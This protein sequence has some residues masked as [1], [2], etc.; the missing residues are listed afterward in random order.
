MNGKLFVALILLALVIAL[1]VGG[2]A[3]Y[4]WLYQYNSGSLF[5]YVHSVNDQFAPLNDSIVCI[6]NVSGNSTTIF[7]PKLTSE[8]GIINYSNVEKGT[9]EISI[10]SEGYKYFSTTKDVI[11]NRT[12]SKILKFGPT[13]ENQ[14]NVRLTG[15]PSFIDLDATKN[16]NKTIV[17]LLISINF[18]GEFTIK[19]EN[20]QL[21]LEYPLGVN[22][23]I[24]KPTVSL[25][26]GDT[27]SALVTLSLTP[28]AKTG[29]YGVTFSAYDASKTVVINVAK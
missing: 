25:R 27:V 1:P 10:V 4:T 18:T 13:P 14:T 2:V 8:I 23:Q 12:N 29:Y 11:Y 24:D 7:I 9:Y 6:R 22:I 16:E 20:S 19:T 15:Q 26:P 28:D 21:P 17:L 5:I 3:V